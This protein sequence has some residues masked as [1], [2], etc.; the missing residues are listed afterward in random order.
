MANDA[1]GAAGGA[2]SSTA[3]LNSPSFMGALQSFLNAGGLNN[4]QGISGLSTVGGLMS[5]PSS[6]IYSP[7]HYLYQISW[8]AGEQ[9]ARDYVP[10]DVAARLYPNPN[11][12]AEKGATGA[13]NSPTPSLA[14]VLNMLVGPAPVAPTAA[15]FG[16][17]PTLG[18]FFS[19]APYQQAQAQ[20]ASGNKTAQGTVNNA[21]AQAAKQMGAIGTQ[22]NRNTAIAEAQA[23]ADEARAANAVQGF[24]NQAGQ[25]AGAGGQVQ[26]RLAALQGI[27]AGQQGAAKTLNAQLAGIQQ[28]NMSQDQ[29]ALT[30]GRQ[31][32][33]NY[34]ASAVLG[35]GS[36]IRLSEATDQA[37]AQQELASANNAR[38]VDMARANAS[39]QS[40]LKSYQA[41][42]QKY[43]GLAAKGVGGAGGTDWAKSQQAQWETSAL[44]GDSQSAGLAAAANRLIA[45][46]TANGTTKAATYEQALQ[47]L[48]VN[49]NQL[50]G[51]G[52][53]QFDTM[54]NWLQNYYNVKKTGS[55]AAPTSAQEAQYLYN[56]YLG[57]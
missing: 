49:A 51:V 38:A 2:V 23:N 7:S 28:N 32:A 22:A 42:V 34:L 29:A 25:M 45:P 3:G 4:L 18:D 12:T 24:A 48:M 31:N 27:L 6:S 41:Q 26:G 47:R 16:A 56:T 20:L 44:Q 1:L 40:A 54:S 10:P 55:G 21:Y 30:S 13:T 52:S 46:V 8:P 5:G 9:N 50:G 15:V 36:K 37:R 14:E 53:A 43:M 17:A 35:E 33:L 57:G 11:V 39:Y 19:A